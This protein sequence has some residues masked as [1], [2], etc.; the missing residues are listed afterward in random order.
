MAFEKEAAVKKLRELEAKQAALTHAGGL[1]YCDGVTVAPEDS[2]EGRART[3]GVLS[4]MEY[5]L[6]AAPETQRLLDELEEHCDELDEQVR[7]ESKV[8]RRETGKIIKIPA[9]EYMQYSM[10]TSEASSVWIRAKNSNDFALFAPYLEKLIAANRRMAELWNPKEEPYN[11]LLDSFEEGLT[12]SAC[13]EF[14][15]TVRQGIVP[16]IEKIRQVQRPHEAFALLNYPADGQE[17]LAHALMQLEG[18]D[19]KRCVLGTTEHP[20]TCGFNNRDLRITT[21]YHENAVL[22]SV[23]SVLHE[24]GH[25]LYEMNGDD[26]FNYT[27][28]YGGASMGVHESQSRFYENIIGRSRSFAGP[29]LKTC[30]EIFPEQLAG[31]TEEQFY[32]EIN[33][34]EPSLIRTE[35]DELTYSLHVMVRYEIEKQLIGGELSVAELPEVWNGLYEEYLGIRPQNNREGCL[36]DSHWSGGAF[37]YF[38]SYALGSAYGAQMLLRMEEQVPAVWDSIAS[39]DLS[40]ATAWLRE[41]IHQYSALYPPMELLERTC[42]TFD[43]SCYIRYLTGKFSSL[44]NL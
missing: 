42:G 6:A 40:P 24:G 9:E 33:Y 18:L 12:M 29:L 10:L 11:V 35:A 41:H 8:L 4:E 23:Y 1:L 17:K 31:V 28:L 34:A 14:F 25:A 13:D 30:R 26:R 3:T 16:L 2:V 37:G 36:Q 5:E 39:G 22:S 20:F 19:P 43:P 21:H 38:P 44:Y 27:C 15:A 7:R 32:R